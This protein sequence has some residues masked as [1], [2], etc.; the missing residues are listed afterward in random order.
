MVIRTL[1]ALCAISAMAISCADA[2][3]ISISDR[4]DRTQEMQS[5]GEPSIA[6]ALTATS[7][8]IER[9][10]RLYQRRCGACHSLDANR[11]G[12]K[13]RGV[14][15]RAAGSVPDFRYSNALRELNIIWD[16][17][18][19]D[20]WLENPPAFAPGTAMGVRLADPGEREAIIAYLK[21]LS[22]AD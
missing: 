2:E 6:T 3:A 16:D 1:V 5:E 14:Y 20:S 11:V 17:D 22:T 12:P 9:G 21:S 10:E 15:G 4:Q 7:D 18:T 8:L 13:H 19:L